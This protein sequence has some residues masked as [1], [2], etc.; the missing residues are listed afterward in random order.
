MQPGSDLYGENIGEGQ[1]TDLVAMASRWQETANFNLGSLSGLPSPS[2]RAVRQGSPFA[3][4]AKRMQEQ[5]AKRYNSTAYQRVKNKNELYESG[6]HMMLDK[7]VIQP[8][9]DYKA[10]TQFL[11]LH[12]CMSTF[13]ELKRNVKGKHF[14]Q[15]KK[16]T[17]F[18][19]T[20]QLR[21]V[22]WREERRAKK[23]FMRLV[24]TSWH[25]CARTKQCREVG[26][27]EQ[28]LGAAVEAPAVSSRTPQE[29]QR[30]AN[31]NGTIDSSDRNYLQN[32][33]DTE[34]TGDTN[35]NNS[36]D[37]GHRDSG[38]MNTQSSTALSTAMN[39]QRESGGI[40][41]ALSTQR[42]SAGL[43]T[44]RESVRMPQA[45]STQRESAIGTERASR[46]T[47]TSANDVRATMNS[48]KEK[49]AAKLS[50]GRQ[51]IGV[52]G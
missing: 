24:F 23:W 13:D 28:D 16:L 6:L 45:L 12:R 18:R 51:G 37:T 40:S 4:K 32:I 7:R 21:A 10:K 52:D 46:I 35:L 8:A 39:T 3:M 5:I 36:L 47:A 42:D 15:W 27:D 34:R 44:Q 38:R 41:A 49:V 20:T 1:L 19:N 26:Y 43:G 50:A 25:Y 31:L 17:F 29:T 11:V 30:T 2:S 9:V 22:Q 48:I 33:P 14:Q